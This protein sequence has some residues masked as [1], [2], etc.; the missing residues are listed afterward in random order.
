MKFT[1][2]ALKFLNL[3][4]ESELAAYVFYKKALK[5]ITDPA[6]KETVEKL[7]ADEKGHFLSLEDEYDENVRS[8]CWAPYRDIMEKPGLPE[9]DEMLQETHVYLLDR[10]KSMKTRK[11]FLD[12][13]LML[14]KEAL[15]LFTDAAATVTNPEF[16]KVFEHLASFEQGH[17]QIIER[18]LANL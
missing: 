8:E 13:A 17:V 12:I 7:A 10:V 5:L 3:G 15:K 6:L 2:D 14:E 1:E 18:E 16:K 4:I 9:I 11:E